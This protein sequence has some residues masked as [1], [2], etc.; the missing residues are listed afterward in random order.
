MLKYLRTRLLAFLRRTLAT[1]WWV[2]EFRKTVSQTGAYILLIA[3]ERRKMSDSDDWIYDIVPPAQ[4]ESMNHQA[5]L[6]E[7]RMTGGVSIVLSADNQTAV[8][9]CQHFT[10]AM[11]GEALAWVKVTSFLYGII[12]TLEQHLQEEGINPYEED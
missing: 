1:L 11:R 3:K 2:R 5:E 4:V 8:E 6:I 9:L 7:R 12:S 10:R